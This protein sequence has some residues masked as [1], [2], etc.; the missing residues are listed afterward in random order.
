MPE[1]FTAKDSAEREPIL[2]RAGEL[3]SL[4]GLFARV[5][6]GVGEVALIEGEAGIGKSRLLEEALRDAAREGFKVL[7]GAADQLERDQPFGAIG[8]ALK[9]LLRSPDSQAA[10]L[11][12]ML[13]GEAP[14]GGAL[15]VATGIPDLGFR[16][17]ESIVTLLERLAERAPVVVG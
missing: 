5:Q 16:I 1:T 14:D 15:A 7:C 2:G 17:V 11:A 4:R 3:A 8:D 13:R 12:R 10:E 6:S 9:L